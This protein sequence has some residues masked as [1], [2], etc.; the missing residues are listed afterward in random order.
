MASDG[1]QQGPTDA[2]EYRVAYF[3]RHIS[4]RYPFWSGVP[5]GAPLK[6]ENNSLRVN[7]G[8]KWSRLSAFSLA[9]KEDIMNRHEELY[10]S[11]KIPS[12]WVFNDFGHMTCFLFRDKNLNGR[13]DN[14][15]KI[16]GEFLH[17][18][19]FDEA[20]TALKRPVTLEPSH[21]CVHLKPA[22]VDE[23]ISRKYLVKG[24]KVIVHRYKDHAPLMI[25]GAKGSGDLEL[26]FYPASRRLY[27]LSR[28]P[29]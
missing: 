17:T 26:Q 12:T 1:F 3:G 2:G 8:G 5:W 11:R 22:D 14:G 27:V 25:L 18:T 7:I 29:F 16:H 10:A 4:R 6:E 9:T 13:M 24:R 15:E 23:M 21:G 28:L 19:P 20:M